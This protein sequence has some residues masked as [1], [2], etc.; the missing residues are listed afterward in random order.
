MQEKEFRERITCKE[1]GST[2]HY[3]GPLLNIILV[4]RRPDSEES[5][6]RVVKKVPEKC[7]N[8]S[9]RVKKCPESPEKKCVEAIL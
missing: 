5:G 7:C 4:L 6:A 9:S 8:P 3:S 2:Q 1:K